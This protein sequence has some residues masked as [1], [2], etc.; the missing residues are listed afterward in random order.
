MF[1]DI[2]GIFQYEKNK[3][4]VK[5]EQG[6]DHVQGG[7]DEEG[8]D[9]VEGPVSTPVFDSIYYLILLSEISIHTNQRHS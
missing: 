8:K 6:E 5:T 3:W 4:M 1:S 2:S 9:S 7:D